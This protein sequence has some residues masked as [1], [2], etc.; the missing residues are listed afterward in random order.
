MQ[1]GD[2]INSLG[3]LNFVKLTSFSK[4]I[5]PN[6]NLKYKTLIMQI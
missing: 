3:G 4:E 2:G 5:F 1:K 6:L